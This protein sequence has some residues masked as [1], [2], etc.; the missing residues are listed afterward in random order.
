MSNSLLAYLLRALGWLGLALLLVVILLSD[1]LAQAPAGAT[2]PS[3][4]LLP[5]SPGHPFG[6]DVLGRDVFSETVHGL[7]QTGRHAIA[8]A[9]ISIFAGG[10]FGVVAA[11]L[12]KTVAL[13]LHG[14]IGV[15]ASVP[16]LLLTIVIV[17]LGGHDKL[18]Y[19]AGLAVAPLSFLRGFAS[20]DL[21]SA[22]A[23][24][25]QATGIS[26]VSLLRRDLTYDFQHILPQVLARALAAV[27]ILVSTASFLGFGASPPERD[28]G[29]I[30]AA[31]KASYLTQWWTA[32][33]PALVL[34]TFVLCARLAAGL[35]EGERA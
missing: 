34:V 11:R 3:A 29:L 18:A 19:A 32:F 4:A 23:R 35:E 9:V 24:Y 17:G 22:H 12:P 20:V 10:F 27:T 28:L 16:A 7:H 6:T 14:L 15:L 33:F 2:L 13:C 8:A 30:I 5:P 26:G 25:A 31:A 21:S 1:F